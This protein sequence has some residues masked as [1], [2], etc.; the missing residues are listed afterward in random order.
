MK[1]DET[2]VDEL[3]RIYREKDKLYEIVERLKKYR[4]KI[5]KVGWD[6]ACISPS[7]FQEI[8]SGDKDEK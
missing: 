7:I 6:S 5:N 2:L 3:L 8:I 1:T 4:D